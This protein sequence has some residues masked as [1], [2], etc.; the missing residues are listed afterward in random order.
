MKKICL[1]AIVVLTFYSCSCRNGNHRKEA[2]MQATFSA[3]ASDSA[4]IFQHFIP[5]DTANKMIGSYLAS[6]GADS[7][8]LNSL[9]ID[10]NAL[11]YY[12][13]DTSIRKIKIMFAHTLDYIYSGHEGVPAGY[14]KDALTIILAGYDLDDNY[15]FA[16]G[17]MVPDHAVPCPDLCPVSGTAADNLL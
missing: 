1:Y 15:R 8:C 17:N 13:Q 10:A 6:I 2:S 12:L 16:P 9:I 4:L 11:R 14:K 7:S 5:A 3:I